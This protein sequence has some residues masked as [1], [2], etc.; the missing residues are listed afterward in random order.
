ME[1]QFIKVVLGFFMVLLAIPNTYAIETPDNNKDKNNIPQEVSIWLNKELA[2]TITQ[3]LKS[4]E[5]PEFYTSKN[6][7]IVGYI[8]GYD[9]SQGA[10]TGIYNYHNNITYTTYPKVIK[11]YED[12]RFELELSLDY[13]LYHFFKIEGKTISFY[14]EPGQ[15]LSIILDWNDLKKKNNSC[16]YKKAVYQGTLKKMNHDLLNYGDE[17]LFRKLRKMIKEMNASDFKREAIKVKDEEVAKI[18]AYEYSG[19]IGFKTRELLINNIELVVCRYLFDYFSYRERKQITTE[20]ELIPSDYYDFVNELPLNK[21]SFLINS[22]DCSSI[23]DGIRNSPFLEVEENKKRSTE[24][25]VYTLD[26]I[27]FLEKKGIEVSDEDKSFIKNFSDNIYN[28]ENLSDE[29]KKK[30]KKFYNRYKNHAKNYLDSERVKNIYSNMVLNDEVDKWKKK[31]SLATSNRVKDNLMYEIAKMRTL[32]NMF[33]I[34]TLTNEGKK[35]LWSYVKK[36]I[37]SSY[38]RKCGDEYVAKKMVDKVPKNEPGTT[39][40]NNIISPYNNKVI[41]MEFWSDGYR[42]NEGGWL[43]FTKEMRALFKG[44]EEVEFLLITNEKTITEEKFKEHVK[45]YNYENALRI[46]EREF[47]YLRQ[48]FVLFNKTGE[49]IVDTERNVIKDFNYLGTRFLLEREYN[50]LPT[51]QEQYL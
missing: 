24:V 42:G 45:K 22:N 40:F 16:Y 10:K 8:K 44:S 9:K 46:S 41:V 25:G 3:V 37:T 2:N 11:I 43:G 6:A 14:V 35:Q 36:E 47:R 34:H 1:K 18:K 28:D 50:I 31:D 12:G 33:G 20:K 51:S 13:P 7:K 32:R 27:R 30:E 5:V 4:F 26:F 38:L 21:Q 19:E 48:L 23:A 49:V 39:V 17:N 15:N 29:L